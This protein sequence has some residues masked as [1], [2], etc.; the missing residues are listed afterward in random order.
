MSIPT[1]THGYDGV[2][3]G[4]PP[5]YSRAQSYPGAEN[6]VHNLNSPTQSYQT[7]G[8]KV[9]RP[10]GP[11]HIHTS[12][13]LP[14]R[15]VS[16]ATTRHYEPGHPQHET[17]HPPPKAYPAEPEAV[18]RKRTLLKNEAKKFTKNKWVRTGAK[19][20]GTIALSAVVGG[21]AT[22]LMDGVLSIGDGFSGVDSGGFDTGDFDFGSA[23]VSNDAGVTDGGPSAAAS[24]ALPQTGLATTD[25]IANQSWNNVT[26]PSTGW[27]TNTTALHV[28]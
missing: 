9:M 13:T 3:F 4:N 8:Q 15:P 7:S 20:F 26:L 19:V 27:N 14:S 2:Y 21:V 17:F 24:N 22:D 6:H 1:N 5:P 23:D 16:Q 18:A 10:N 12:P 11:Q 28:G 25:W